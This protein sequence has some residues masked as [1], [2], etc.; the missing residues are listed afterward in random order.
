M[1][2]RRERRG[3]ELRTVHYADLRLPARLPVDLRLRV[4]GRARP[5]RTAGAQTARCRR[6]CRSLDAAPGRPSPVAAPRAA[7]GRCATAST[8]VPRADRD[9]GAA[10]STPTPTCDRARSP[11]ASADRRGADR[12]RP[13]GRLHR[14]GLRD[15]RHDARG[16]AVE[17]AAAQGVR[18]VDRDQA[19]RR[20]RPGTWCG[21]AAFAT[22]PRPSP[23][24]ASCGRRRGWRR[25]R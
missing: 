2:E 23:W 14:A 21:S 1:A 18:A 22:T 8:A 6:E 4:L 20:R 5:R 11:T 17:D 15:Q 19:Y 9:A 3:A 7:G 12:R 25:R 16:D 13:V 10:A 24:R